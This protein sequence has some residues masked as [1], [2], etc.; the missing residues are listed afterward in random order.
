[1]CVLDGIGTMGTYYQINNETKEECI[2]LSHFTTIKYGAFG[3]SSLQ[4]AILT[5]FLGFEWHRSGVDFGPYLGRW[6]KDGLR[7]ANDSEDDLQDFP[8]VGSEF[9]VY[10]AKKETLLAWLRHIEY[11]YGLGDSTGVWLIKMSVDELKTIDKE[12]KYKL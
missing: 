9:L 12:G 4:M 3:P 10:L 7:I 1:M 2:C 8:D 5:V 6:I 11:Y